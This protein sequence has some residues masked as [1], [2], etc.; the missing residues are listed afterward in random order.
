MYL[1]QAGSKEHTLEELPHPLEELIHVGPLQHIHLQRQQ[2][3]NWSVMAAAGGGL[4][5]TPM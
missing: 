2:T 3:A 4:G 1:S 5:P